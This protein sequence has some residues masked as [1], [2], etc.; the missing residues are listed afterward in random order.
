MERN[1][2]H[3][4]FHIQE[5][6]TNTKAIFKLIRRL[7]AHIN[8]PIIYAIWKSLIT[9]FSVLRIEASHLCNC[10]YELKD[11]LLTPSNV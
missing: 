8:I 5:M 9:L 6:I 2:I 11:N 10:N 3:K 1:H 7:L 4:V